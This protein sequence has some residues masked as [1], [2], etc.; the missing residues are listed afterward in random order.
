MRDLE[1]KQFYSWNRKFFINEKRV[2][3]KFLGKRL[4]FFSNHYYKTSMM[5][6]RKLPNKESIERG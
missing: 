6:L 2:E 3:M 1:T 4:E 5:N